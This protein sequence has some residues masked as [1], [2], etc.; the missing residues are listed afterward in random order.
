MPAFQPSEIAKFIVV[1]TLS[2]FLERKSPRPEFLEDRFIW[3]NYHRHSFFLILRQPDLGTALVL[4]PIT[5]VMFYFGN[6]HPWVI[7]TMTL[8]G[9]CGAFI[10]GS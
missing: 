9:D 3:R 5:L 1:I 6:I 8:L 2:W 4:F 10:C 7:R